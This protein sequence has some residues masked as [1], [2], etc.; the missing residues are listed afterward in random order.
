MEKAKSQN[1][2]DDDAWKPFAMTFESIGVRENTKKIIIALA[3][4][5]AIME[6]IAWGETIWTWWKGEEGDKLE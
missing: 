2:P 4:V 6:L 3:F 5:T 1:T